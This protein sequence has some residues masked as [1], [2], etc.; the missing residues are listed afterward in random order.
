MLVET[1]RGT[2]MSCQTYPRTHCGSKDPGYVSER[3]RSDFGGR[4]FPLERR[5]I[6]LVCA[7]LTHPF[8]GSDREGRSVWLVAPWGHGS[9]CWA[10]S[11]GAPVIG[12]EESRLIRRPSVSSQTKRPRLGGNCWSRGQKVRLLLNLLGWSLVRH[13]ASDLDEHTLGKGDAFGNQSSCSLPFRR[14]HSKVGMACL[15]IE[16]TSKRGSGLPLIAN[17][18]QHWTP[19][20]RIP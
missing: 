5:P 12:A 8:S 3:F 15:W 13:G 4:S 16:S 18:S 6:S 19:M 9:R 20:L 7:C 11:C 14:I 2:L 10:G 1:C 17:G